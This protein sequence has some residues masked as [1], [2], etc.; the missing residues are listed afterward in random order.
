LPILLRSALHA[1]ERVPAAREGMEMVRMMEGG[2]DHASN[3]AAGA[4][5]VNV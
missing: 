4:R 3:L 1:C 2:P 5:P